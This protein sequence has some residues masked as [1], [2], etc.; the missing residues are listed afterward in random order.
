MEIEKRIN[1]L[2]E[3]LN[4]ANYQY[5]IEDNSIITDQ[6]FDKYLK[7]LTEL[8]MEYPVYKRNDSPTQ[9]V[10]GNVLEEF[11][12][13]THRI[14][15]L[16]IEDVFNEEEIINFEQKIRKEGYHPEYVCEL[17]IDGL[18]ISAYYEDGVLVRAAT[19]GNGRVGDDI[20]T[21]AKTIKNLPLKLKEA[22]TIEVRVEIYMSRDTVKKLN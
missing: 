6:E 2:T 14:P 18:S 20:T 13:V 22:V 15:M 21:N 17:K 5:Y 3:L 19:R 9:R 11:K 4:E 12:K 8:E 16:S 10:G 7:E 1:E